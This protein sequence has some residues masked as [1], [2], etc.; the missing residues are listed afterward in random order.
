MPVAHLVD[1]DG[2]LLR[3]RPRLAGVTRCVQLPLEFSLQRLR[4]RQ[5]P[6]PVGVR[7]IR[8]Q[9]RVTLALVSRAGEVRRGQQGAKQWEGCTP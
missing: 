1:S 9:L 3:R 7:V 5:R 4:R 6:Q 8:P 2:Q